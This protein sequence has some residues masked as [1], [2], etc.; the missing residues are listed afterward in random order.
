VT[1]PARIL[2]RRQIQV[3]TLA[4]NGNS[5]ADIGR[6][7]W[8]TPDT[9]NGV[10]RYAYRALGVTDR[11]HAVAVALRL[12]LIGLE[13]IRL[14]ETAPVA[15]SR[16]LVAPVPPAGV[17]EARGERPAPTEPPEARSDI[18]APTGTGPRKPLRAP[19]AVQ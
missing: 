6:W 18:S 15:P 11:A 19:L 9:V 7:L 4:A 16:A 13:E 2:T 1:A 10:L 8:V 3:L 14:P 5:A 17:P 12:G